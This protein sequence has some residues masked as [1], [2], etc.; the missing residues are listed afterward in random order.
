MAR[1]RGTRG[2][3]HRYGTRWGLFPTHGNLRD[4]DILESGLHT[5]LFPQF[6]HEIA[7]N[8]C[9]R[10]IPCAIPAHAPA[11]APERIVAAPPAR[12]SSYTLPLI[13]V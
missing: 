6:A 1:P 12:E 10:V 13:V 4:D 8:V 3:Q 2:G 5:R 9:T 11:H 7:H